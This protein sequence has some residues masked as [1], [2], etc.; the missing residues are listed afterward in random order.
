VQTTQHV[1]I[2]Q[3]TIFDIGMH[4]GNDTDFYLRKG[5]KVVAVEANPVLVDKCRERFQSF[6]DTGQLVI[7]NVG[8]GEAEGSFPFYINLDN[9]E[10]SSFN[11]HRGTR[12]GSKYDVK[13][14]RCVTT[15]SLFQKH[16]MP[17]FLKIDIEGL[18]WL[19]VS[20]LHDFSVRPSYISVEDNSFQSL[21]QLHN[22]GVKSY[23]FVDQVDKWNMLPPNP[24]LEGAFVA[25][26]FGAATSGL[27]GRELPG[28]WLPLDAAAKFY[29]ENIRPPGVGLKNKHWW[30]I[31]GRF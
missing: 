25:T 22:A 8:I 5:F 1:P 14:I 15:A 17:Y 3:D 11:V 21:I 16:G 27:F 31:H 7:E 10:W 26:R 24:A 6:E 2:K 4:H 30:D 28:D 23:K 29:L 20:A 13:D 12:H 18:D 19:P 9:D